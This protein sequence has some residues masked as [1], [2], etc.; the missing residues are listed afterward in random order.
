MD[1]TRLGK[2]RSRQFPGITARLGLALGLGVAFGLVLGPRAEPLG[3][4]GLA[5]IKVLKMFATPLIFLAII[6]AFLRTSIRGSQ[7]L[8]LLGISSLNACVAALI[9]VS[10]THLAP[11]DQ[12]LD[13]PNLRLQLQAG[14]PPAAAAPT[15]DASKIIDSFIPK[16]IVQPFLDN[17]TIAVILLAIV[18]GFALRKSRAMTADDSDPLPAMVSYA[19]KATTLI[20]EW[21]VACVPLAA[22]FVIAKIAGSSGLATLH[23]LLVFVG[24]VTAGLFIHVVVYYSIL[25]RAI[26]GTSAWQF[27]KTSGEALLTAFST[28]SSLATLPVTLRTL[29]EKMRISPQ[30]ARLAACVGTNLNHDG[31]LLYEA[32]A[33]LFVAKIYGI[34]LSLSQ[35]IVLIL[36]SVLA[37][38]GIAGVP[39]AGLITLSLVL[40]AVNLPLAAVPLLLPVD[41]FLGRLRATTNVASDLVVANLLEK[42]EPEAGLA[43]SPAIESR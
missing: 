32:V 24:L 42:S 8:R 2:R 35:E 16:S 20:L 1:P 39:D 37:A 41:W 25:I 30:S 11:I 33:A 31:I 7:G 14:I 40:G 38:V 28:G 34:H 4:I 21:I 23:A 17:N 6:D 9:A 5:I 18:L 10:L 27:F 26:T 19:L 22:F 43:P 29:Q 36:T 13:L 15:L 12:W 3:D